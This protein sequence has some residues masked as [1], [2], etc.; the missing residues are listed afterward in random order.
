[1]D[2]VV[3]AVPFFIIALVVELASVGAVDAGQH[4]HQGGLAGTVLP[5]Q[6][7]QRVHTGEA[8]AHQVLRTVGDV[9]QLGAI[10]HHERDV[11]D[12][13]RPQQPKMTVQQRLA[14]CVDRAR[15]L[16]DALLALP[17]VRDAAVDV[18]T[19]RAHAVA[20]S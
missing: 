2:L 3:Y 20:T 19:G 13:G 5:H 18:M 12:P 10:A 8:V 4:L 6:A 9:E 15:Q 7:H 17:P 11:I 1:M 16:H 14:A